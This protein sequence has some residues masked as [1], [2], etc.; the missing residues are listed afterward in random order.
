MSESDLRVIVVTHGNIGA[1][2]VDVACHIV[3]DVPGLAAVGIEWE[4]EPEKVI[5][6]IEE[7]IE[8]QR[9]GADLLILTDMFGGTSTNVGLSFLERGRIELVTGVNLPMIVKLASILVGRAGSEGPSL[10]EV[11]AA[12]RDQ[13]RRSIEVASELIEKR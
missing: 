5:R 2:L 1:A 10:S 9:A 8:G 4:D 7:A 6:T 13:G 12:I 3:G 11:A